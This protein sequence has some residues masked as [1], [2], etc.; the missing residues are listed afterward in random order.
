MKGGGLVAKLCPT[1][2]TLCTVARQAPL[3][4][5]FPWQDYWSGLP[6][7]SPGDLPNPGIQPVSPPLPS[8]SL[9]TELSGK[10][11]TVLYS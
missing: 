9:P 2:A 8:E 4:M 6:F 10:P 1:L 5:E 7:L 11:M 3:S